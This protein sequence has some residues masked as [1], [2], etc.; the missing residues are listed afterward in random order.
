MEFEYALQLL[1]STKTI[2][3]HY[4]RFICL[5]SFHNPFSLDSSVTTVN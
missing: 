1:Q 5:S 4:L 2:Y 3:F